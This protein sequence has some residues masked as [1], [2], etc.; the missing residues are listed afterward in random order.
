MLYRRRDSGTKAY[1]EKVGVHTR[2]KPPVRHLGVSGRT[3]AERAKARAKTRS[4]SAAAAPASGRS[5]SGTGKGKKRA[6]EAF[7]VGDAGGNDWG[8]WD[9]ETDPDGIV[10]DYADGKETKDRTSCVQLCV[11]I[12]SS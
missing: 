1:I 2:P 3:A 9:E 4:A 8:E 12:D 7:D 6:A 10:W 5:A 11:P